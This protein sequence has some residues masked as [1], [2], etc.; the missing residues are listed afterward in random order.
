LGTVHLTSSRD[1]SSSSSSSSSYS[2][3]ENLKKNTTPTQ[4]EEEEQPERVST[5]N[6]QRTKELVGECLS[7]DSEA[8]RCLL[9]KLTVTLLGLTLVFGD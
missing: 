5:A 9:L 1:S 7:V 8:L 2:P 6:K 3:D 4:G